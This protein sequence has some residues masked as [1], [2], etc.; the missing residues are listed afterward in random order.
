MRKRFVPEG[1]PIIVTPGGRQNNLVK[2]MLLGFGLM[3]LYGLVLGPVIRTLLPKAYLLI[4]ISMAMAMVLMLNV[5]NKRTLY[6]Y[7]DRIVEKRALHPAHTFYFYNVT[8]IKKCRGL[9]YHIQFGHR[10]LTIPL[11]L[12]NAEAILSSMERYFKHKD[13][14]VPISLLRILKEIQVSA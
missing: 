1:N 9:K 13:N 5:P 10:R 7:R 11:H 2:R 3:L 6:V 14:V 4:S 12:T 8:Q